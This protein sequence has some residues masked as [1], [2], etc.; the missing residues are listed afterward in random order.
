VLTQA[1]LRAF[2]ESISSISSCPRTPG[3][4][5]LLSCGRCCSNPVTLD[6]SSLD[7]SVANRIG[8]R[9]AR[10]P[11]RSVDFDTEDLLMTR[12]CPVTSR[13]GSHSPALSESCASSRNLG[14]SA[15]PLKDRNPCFM[16]MRRFTARCLLERCCS[17]RASATTAAA[18]EFALPLSSVTLR[19]RWFPSS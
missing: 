5:T 18:S 15:A 1:A 9:F 13:F 10:S 4:H 2:L 6:S 7:G 17:D 12:T 8:R 16:W 14:S 3:T 11:K 19:I